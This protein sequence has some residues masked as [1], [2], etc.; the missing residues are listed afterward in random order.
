MTPPHSHR[1][2]ALSRDNR[3]V[4]RVRDLGELV[5]AIPAMLG[6]HPRDSLVLMAT[7]GRSGRR[8]GLTLRVDLPPPEIP[9]YAEHAE[10]VVASAVRGL[11]LDKPAGAVAVV[12][13]P[14]TGNPPDCLPHPRLARLIAQSLAGR[15]VDVHTLLWAESTAGGARWACYDSCGCSGRVPDPAATE[16]VA[17]TVVDGRV[18]HPDRAALERLVTP[19]DRDRLRRRE[20]L[21]IGGTD[22]EGGSV[23]AD[24]A[25]GIALVDAAL[26]DAAAGRLAL[27]D[28]RVVALAQAL[29]IPAVRDVALRRSAGRRAAAAEQLWAAL[30]RETPDPEAALPAALLALSAL[31]RG[32]GALANIAL[33][34]AQQAWPGHLLSDVLRAVAEAGYRPE[35]VREWLHRSLRPELAPPARGAA[36]GAMRSARRRRRSRRAT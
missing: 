35:Q 15:G 32:D 34:R 9:A 3:P 26:A 31:L 6:F 13:A 7:G 29:G 12:V 17:A 8:L 2:T 23:G 20:E 19:V 28:D 21:L 10:L 22:G 25:A 24:A 5:A 14:S 18:V 36:G 27:S 1:F 4:V 30:A 11:L 33:D 16:F